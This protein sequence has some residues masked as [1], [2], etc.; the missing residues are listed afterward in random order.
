MPTIT[1]MIS[2]DVPDGVTVTSNLT[3]SATDTTGL[4]SEAASAGAPRTG[5]TGIDRYPEVVAR[6][7][8]LVPARFRPFVREYARRCVEEL[9]CELT[10]PDSDR[11]EE[12]FNVY[13]PPYCRRSRVAGVTYSSSRT[14][15]FTGPIELEGFEVAEPTYNSG[16]YAYP[17]LAQ[18]ATDEAV[19]EAIRLSVQAIDRL[20]R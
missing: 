18:L 14:G 8:R 2:I 11:R 12:Y 1:F 20:T 16:R 4:R 5:P 6:I 15:V 13:P 7:D 19:N 17:K 10:L 3:D 9:D